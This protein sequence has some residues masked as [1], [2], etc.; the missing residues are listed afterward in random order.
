VITQAIAKQVELVRKVNP[1]ADMIANMWSEGAEMVHQ[2]LIKLPEGVTLVWPDK[3]EGMIQDNGKVRAGQGIYYHTAMLNGRCNQLTE[4]VNPGRIYNQV[5]RF[6]KAGAT[7]FFLVNVSDVRPVPLSTDC[8]MKLAWNA[9]PYLD[10]TDEQNMLVFYEDWSARQFGA[11]LSGRV[12]EVYKDYF[13]CPYMN[14]TGLKGENYVQGRMRLMFDKAMP[15]IKAGKPLG[16]DVLKRR[17]ELSALSRDG[18]AHME[19]VLARAEQL[20]PLIPAGR[21]DFYQSHILT[22]IQIHL[23]SLAT[24]KAGC[25]ALTEYESGDKAKAISTVES[26]LQIFDKLYPELRKAE[27]GKWTAWFEG[28]CFLGLERTRIKITD[29]LATLKVEA[30]LVKPYRWE[31]YSYEDLYRYQTIHPENFP[32]LYPKRTD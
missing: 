6:V 22:Q 25:Q 8:A 5:G 27:Y 15:L 11:E 32:L 30:E 19:K 7:K 9:K 31:D 23:I 29:M 12:S 2:G 1:N 13:N 18:L 26:Q 21:K 24:L 10:K 20:L 16:E 28:E 4:M 17:D 3:G 14:D